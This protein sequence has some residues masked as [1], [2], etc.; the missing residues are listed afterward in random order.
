MP[1]GWFLRAA[2]VPMMRPAVMPASRL[3]AHQGGPAF[4][5]VLRAA[6]A[7]AKDEREDD[8]HG[9]EDEGRHGLSRHRV[10]RVRVQRQHGMRRREGRQGAAHPPSALRRRR[11]RGG[12]QA[13]AHRGA[14]QG[15]RARR[16]DAAPAAVPEL[17]EA[18]LFEEPRAVSYEA[19]GLGPAGGAQHAQ[20]RRVQVRAHHV[21]RGHH[22]HCRRDQARPRRV[23]PLG[24]PVPG[25]RARRDQGGPRSA[26]TPARP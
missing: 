24:H 21:G 6:P 19:R 2:R 17:Q 1:S 26:R 14:R 22:P 5:L 12:A 25:R 15:V 9:Y 8:A 10:V 13:L 18:H 7:G 16:Q 11:E 4:G 23:R 20:P 3:A